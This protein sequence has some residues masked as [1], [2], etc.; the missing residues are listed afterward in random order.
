MI[1]RRYH[2]TY[3]HKKQKQKGNV[4][5]TLNTL[6]CKHDNR[7][8]S[9]SSAFHN[10]D[11]IFQRVPSFEVILF[12]HSQTTFITCECIAF[13]MVNIQVRNTPIMNESPNCECHDP[14]AMVA[15]CKEIL[16]IGQQEILE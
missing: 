12:E 1:E 9:T 3:V 13:H 5:S 6:P 7:L 4:R 15:R 11:P 10:R 8:S 2:D 14:F 16:E